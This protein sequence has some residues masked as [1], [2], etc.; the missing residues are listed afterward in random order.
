MPVSG[1]QITD[2]QEFRRPLPAANCQLPARRSFSVVG[3]TAHRPY[4]FQ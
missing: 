2:I 4:A 3:P 1:L